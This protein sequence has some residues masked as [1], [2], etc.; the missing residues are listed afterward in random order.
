MYY[1][2]TYLFD[3]VQDTIYKTA[4]TDSIYIPEGEAYQLKINL[5]PQQAALNLQVVLPENLSGEILF[6]ST[7]STLRS[8]EPAEIIFSEFFPNPTESQSGA[9]SQWIEIYNRSQDS[10][11]LSD[12]RISKTRSSSSVST[13]YDFP[14]DLMILPG[15]PLVFGR[16]LA[17][18]KDYPF[19]FRMVSTK[20]SLLFLC[21]TQ[22]E[23]LLIDSLSY[24]TEYESIDSIYSVQ[25]Y[26]NSKRVT[27]LNQPSRNT[28]WC[29]SAPSTVEGYPLATPGNIITNCPEN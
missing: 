29:L 15:E 22:D 8:P 17:L 9:E 20:Q 19:E 6:Q 7:A 14:A 11:I 28:H 5:T 27:D 24:T 4:T 12:C 23:T 3:S 2:E 16:S 10:L 26:S 25:G 18:N 13:R 21:D 1:I